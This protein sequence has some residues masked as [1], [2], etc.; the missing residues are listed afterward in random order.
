MAGFSFSDRVRE[1]RDYMS[2]LA[3][4]HLGVP[5]EELDCV[6][7]ENVWNILLRLLLL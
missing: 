6:A 7:G 1:L 5:Q 3:W 4:E 2:R